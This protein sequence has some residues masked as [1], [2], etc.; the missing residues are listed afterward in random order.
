MLLNLSVLNPLFLPL[1]IKEIAI[2]Q[3]LF[4]SPLLTL[5][6]FP[7]I[8]VYSLNGILFLKTDQHAPS[9]LCN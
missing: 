3:I 5:L 1:S 7:F 9:H 2:S 8:Y 6:S 4:Q